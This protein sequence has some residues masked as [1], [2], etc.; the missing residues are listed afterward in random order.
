MKKVICILLIAL[1]ASLAFSQ[2]ADDAS[3]DAL[4]FAASTMKVP[5]YQMWGFGVS[6]G[7]MQNKK[8]DSRVFNTGSKY[9]DPYFIFHAQWGINKNLGVSGGLNY[10]VMALGRGIS[11]YDGWAEGCKTWAGS[12]TEMMNIYTLGL[13]YA[14]GLFPAVFYAFCG[15]DIDVYFDYHPYYN[16]WL[17]TKIG[18]GFSNEPSN[19]YD[20]WKAS[21]FIQPF[22]S[23]R[24]QADF[25]KGKVIGS[26]FCRYSYDFRR[27]L[28]K[29][30]LTE[31]AHDIYMEKLTIGAEVGF[32]ARTREQRRADRKA[33]RA[34]RKA[35][36][37]ER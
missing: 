36:R 35:A 32:K 30:L 17:D 24:G 4:D 12:E 14:I 37:A 11:F 26:V 9:I 13:P 34:E 27:N 5:S 15:L 10:N 16:D 3:S 21:Y 8:Y 31:D 29:W 20:L 1:C 33:K 22:F 18:I 28:D 7:F 25:T 6:S 23:V 2:E 19:Q